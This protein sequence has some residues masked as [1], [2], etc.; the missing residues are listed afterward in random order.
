MSWLKDALRELFGLFVEDVPFTLA[1]IAWIA[2][3]A[4]GLPALAIDAA[5][6]APLLAAGCGLVLAI[7]VFRAALRHRRRLAADPGRGAK[8]QT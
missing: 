3:A 1:L 2:A 8:L 5:W 4:L 6:D 7:S